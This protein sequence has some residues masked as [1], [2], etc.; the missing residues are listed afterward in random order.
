M[1]MIF[2]LD[3]SELQMD[4]WSLKLTKRVIIFLNAE[5]V[6]CQESS[7]VLFLVYLCLLFF[8][9]HVLWVEQQR[10]GRSQW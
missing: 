5:L 4:S 9:R 6:N 2:F 3:P 8:L 10:E 1:G 7:Q